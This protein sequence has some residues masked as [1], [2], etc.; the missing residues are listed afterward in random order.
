M[1]VNAGF[2]QIGHCSPLVGESFASRVDTLFFKASTSSG[3]AVMRFHP[4]MRSNAFM[5]SSK[6]PMAYPFHE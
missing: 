6:S 5:M 1:I 4:G 2:R 3:M